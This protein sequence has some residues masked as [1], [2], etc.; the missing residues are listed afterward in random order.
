ME[1]KF[2]FV[3]RR[4]RDFS[5]ITSLSISRAS[6]VLALFF[7]LF[8]FFGVSLML[9]KTLLKRWFDPAYEQA[10]NTAM[11]RDL[12]EQVDSLHQAV[13]MKDAYINNFKRV[14]LGEQEE[15]VQILQDTLLMDK[16][17]ELDILSKSEATQS[18]IDEFRGQPMDFGGGAVSRGQSIFESYLFPPIKGLVTSK[19]EPQKE[20]FGVDVA[21]RENE[22][23]KSV[24]PGTVVF[25]SWTLE[26]GHVISIQHSNELIS[27]YKHNSVILKKL[28]DV[29]SAGEIISIIGNTGELSTGPHLH[30][31]LWY[32]GSALNPQEFISFD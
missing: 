25:V 8:L 19:F 22:P 29:V 21:A 18:I 4:E 11:L 15:D 12:N 14:M 3:I 1:K 32:K 5:V 17:S 28:G 9:S 2:L 20:H 26:T 16:K 13:A 24:A 10:E 23:V 31:E 6:A 30:F 27:I 7:F